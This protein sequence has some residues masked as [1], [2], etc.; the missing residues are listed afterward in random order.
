MPSLCILLDLTQVSRK[1][2]CKVLWGVQEVHF[3]VWGSEGV[4]SDKGPL[5][6]RRHFWTVNPSPQRGPLAPGP[7]SFSPSPPPFSRQWFRS[8]RGRPPQ[9]FIEP[10]TT[11]IWVSL[12]LV[13]YP[14]V[15]KIVSWFKTRHYVVVVLSSKSHSDPR[16]TSVEAEEPVPGGWRSEGDWG[17]GRVRID[18]GSIPPTTDVSTCPTSE[19]E[20]KNEEE[21]GMYVE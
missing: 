10:R 3:S 11:R 18:G 15:L 19:L 17:R 13:S 6:R 12:F 9:R 8:R 21:V 4:F 20:G 14:K 1:R 5:R 16:R 7:G 2:L